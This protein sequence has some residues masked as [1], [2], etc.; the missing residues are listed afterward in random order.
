MEKNIA[1]LEEILKDEN[2]LKE[3][4]KA[5][6]DAFDLDKSGEIDVKELDVIA[7]KVCE[8]QKLKP[9]TPEAVKS[10]LD[11]FDTNKDGKLNLEEFT[12]FIKLVMEG[13]L[14]FLKKS[15]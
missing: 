8:E 1:E 12:K 11:A 15:K 14:E 10:F 4:A 5:T 2:H 6:F 9:P 7:K 13:A 3:I